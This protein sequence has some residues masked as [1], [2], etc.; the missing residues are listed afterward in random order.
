MDES[1]Y[2]IHSLVVWQDGRCILFAFR[3]GGAVCS[4]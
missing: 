4:L 2:L 3:H 1:T